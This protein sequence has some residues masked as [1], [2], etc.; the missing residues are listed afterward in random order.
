MPEPWEGRR[1]RAILGAIATTGCGIAAFVLLK[2]SG[3]PP[4]IDMAAWL[5][6]TGALN[7]HGL[8]S[9]NGDPLLPTSGRTAGESMS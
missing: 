3:M 7:I 1:L 9:L 5:A 8:L 6:L 4:A 2:A